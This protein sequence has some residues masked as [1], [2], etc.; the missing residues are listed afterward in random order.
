MSS[1]ETIH[2][3]RVLIED[4]YSLLYDCERTDSPTRHIPYLQA[5]EK[6]AMAGRRLGLSYNISQNQETP[7]NDDLV[8]VRLQLAKITTDKLYRAQHRNNADAYKESLKILL[9]V[10]YQVG[11]TFLNGSVKISEILY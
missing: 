7:N 9:N 8:I 6:I 4:A 10:G 3:A 5:V 11:I 1:P 2:E